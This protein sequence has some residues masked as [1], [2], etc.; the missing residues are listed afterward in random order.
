VTEC[1]ESGARCLLLDSDALPPE[2]FDLSTEVLGAAVQWLT[3]QLDS[4]PTS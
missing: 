1:I 3:S 2:F 4:D